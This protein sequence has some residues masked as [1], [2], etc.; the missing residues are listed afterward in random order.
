MKERSPGCGTPLLRALN[1]LDRKTGEVSLALKVLC[2]YISF[3]RNLSFS[4]KMC[5]K[6][7]LRIVLCWA[8]ETSLHRKCLGCLKNRRGCM[9][10]R[11]WNGTIIPRVIVPLLARARRQ[12]RT[13]LRLRRRQ[14][15]MAFWLVYTK[16]SECGVLWALAS[17]CAL[18]CASAHNKPV[19]RCFWRTAA[20]PTPQ[21]GSSTPT[22]WSNWLQQGLSH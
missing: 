22:T 13:R 21:R 1:Q 18:L 4:F 14:P 5:P 17:Y 2:A 12:G 3:G 9:S 8:K 20:V 19:R 6:V 11:L 10:G 16:E 15:G 7:Q